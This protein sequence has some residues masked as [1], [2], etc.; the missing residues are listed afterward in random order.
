MSHYIFENLVQ[1][2]DLDLSDEAMV[3]T[4]TE[5]PTEGGVED[6]YTSGGEF[7][8]YKVNNPSAGYSEGDEYVGYY[9]T[10]L[11]EEGNLK[12]MAGEV[13][14]SAAHNLLM[15]F[16]TKL[17]LPIGDVANYGASHTSDNEQPFFIEKY[18]SIDN[19]KYSP[20]SALDIILANDGELNISDVY[21]GTLELIYA[22]GQIELDFHGTEDEAATTTRQ[23]PSDVVIGIKGKIGVRY[24]LVFSTIIDGQKANV[25]SVEI[26]A[27]DTPISEFPPFEGDSK[28]LLCLLNFLRE[29]VD[30]KLLT[31][32]IFPLNKLVSTL[33][34]YNDMAFL[35]SIGEVTV[36]DD[37]THGLDVSYDQ[38]PGMKALISTVEDDDGNEIVDSITEDPT[39]GWASVLDRSPGLFG[40]LFVNEWDNWNRTLLTRSKVKIKRMFRRHYRNSF[41]RPGDFGLDLPSPGR[42]L[43]NNLRENLRPPAGRTL[44]PWWKR[45]R[46]RRNPY[47]KNGN[48]CEKDEG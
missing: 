10:H 17:S 1:G 6:Q 35:A 32:Y 3:M 48:I 28:T 2:A 26:D 37:S 14:I 36:A 24:G 9:H 13:H 45:R 4:S 44:L 42:I 33:A 15:P 38:K 25:T 46:I 21:P 43:M 19:V 29:D 34:I 20:S 18:I 5:L 39:P 31:R 27:L 8:V 47:D 23:A 40:G 16:S 22:P 41:R 30:F 7:S 12:Y 11:D